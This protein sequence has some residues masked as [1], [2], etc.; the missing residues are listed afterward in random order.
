MICHRR[1]WQKRSMRGQ[2]PGMVKTGYREL[3]GT[4]KR[5]ADSVL[6]YAPSWILGAKGSMEL[7][8]CEVHSKGER[9]ENE[10]H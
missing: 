8:R 9:Y 6:A 4:A 3:C 10:K 7:P 2:S 5:I 1:I